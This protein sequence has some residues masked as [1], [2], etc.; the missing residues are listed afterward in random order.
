VTVDLALLVAGAEGGL[1]QLFLVFLR[2]GAV[3][4]LLPAF[5]EQSVPARVKL[6]IAAALTVLVWPAVA[7]TL[8]PQ[9]LTIGPV[10][11]I[12]GAEVVAG[13]FFGLVLRLFVLTLLTAGSIA[14]QAASLSQLLGGPGGVEPQPA[15]GHVLVISGLALATLLGLHVQVLRYLTASYDLIPAGVWPGAAL[16][17]SVGLAELGRSLSLAFSLAAP[18]TIAALIYNLALGVINRAMPQLMVTFI[19][20]PA[21]TLGGLLLLA[22]AAPAMLAAWAGALSGFLAGQDWGAG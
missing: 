3:A 6:A 11:V 15:I 18:F 10:L 9:P 12:C 16:V 20:A 21:L 19:G 2:V 1:W 8:P 7:G 22:L 17:L 13:L 4:A 5:G 14:A